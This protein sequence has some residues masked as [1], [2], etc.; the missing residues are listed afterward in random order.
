MIKKM[1]SVLLALMLCMTAVAAIAE[2]P[3]SPNGNYVETEKVTSTGILAAPADFMKPV[4]NP[5]PEF[6]AEVE[7]L[8]LVAKMGGDVVS[9]FGVD[10]AALA[11]VLPAGTDASTLKLNDVVAVEPI[12]YDPAY[13]DVSV[14]VKLTTAIE[15]GKTVVVMAGYVDATGVV[16]YVPVAAVAN[17]DGT[18]TINFTTSQLIELNGHALTLAVLEG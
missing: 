16:Q 3:D 17:A 13:G 2:G 8:K 6:A 5:S 14:T 4:A 12:A 10:E 18:L 7:A 15:A 9:Y 1:L 11:S